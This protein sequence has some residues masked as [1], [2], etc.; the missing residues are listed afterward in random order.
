MT[1]FKRNEGTPSFFIVFLLERRGRVVYNTCMEKCFDCPR[2]CSVDRE[3]E[4]GF[5]REGSRI[6]VAK[7]IENFMWEEPLISG[8]K[9]A[10]A[11]FFSGCSLRCNYCQNFQISHIG[12]G[13]SYS[14]EEFASFLKKFDYSKYDSLDLVTPT[15]FSSLL[16]EAFAIFKP[17]VPV[18]WNSSGYEKVETLE[19][20]SFIDVFLVDFKYHSKEL[21]KRLS[22]ADDYFDVARQAISFMIKSRQDKIEDGVLK[23][24]VIVRHLVLPDEVRDSMAVL[25]E[26]AKMGKPILS[27]MRQFT[28][29]GRGEKKRKISSL[30]FKTVLAHALKLGFDK[31][32]VQ[33]EDSASDKYIPSF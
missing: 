18:V 25:D 13:E 11:I 14:P 20:L 12:K 24:G 2:N 26:I 15:H 33:D 5:C 1:Y 9:G 30:E 27:L 8:K 28:P 19:R 7:V 4:K 6:R 22:F 16:K 23:R 3:K 32:F 29:T 31:G 10:L 21:S 17:S